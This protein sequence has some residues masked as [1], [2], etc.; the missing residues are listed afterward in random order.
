M[1]KPRARAGPRQDHTILASSPMRVDSLPGGLTTDPEAQYLRADH[2]RGRKR[3][4]TQT[5]KLSTYLSCA[6]RLRTS[7]RT[8]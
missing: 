8:A 7:G 4:S 1:G 5:K 6:A 3:C 2:W